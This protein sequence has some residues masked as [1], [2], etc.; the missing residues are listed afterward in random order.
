M[1]NQASRFC[2]SYWILFGAFAITPSLAVAGACQSD[3]PEAGRAEQ[4]R[5][6]ESEPELRAFVDPQTGELTSSPPPGEAPDEPFSPDATEDYSGVEFNTRSS[7]EVTAAVGDRFHTELR[8][9]I[10]DGKLV[11]CHARPG[12]AGA[13]P[14]PGPD[15]GSGHTTPHG[16]VH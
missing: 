2:L 9:E 12:G 7:G 16:K 8:A 10:V 14:G 6:A 3:A 13:S 15:L 1:K 11:T 4:P 5:P